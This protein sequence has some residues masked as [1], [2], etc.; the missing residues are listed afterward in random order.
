MR[1]HFNLVHRVSPGQLGLPTEK[2]C[3]KKQNKK[4]QKRKK[5]KEVLFSFTTSGII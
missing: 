5:D 2:A 1:T 4:K 3:L